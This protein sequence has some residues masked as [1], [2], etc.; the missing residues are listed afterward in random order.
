MENFVQAW[1]WFLVQ[2]LGVQVLFTI[3]VL[4]VAVAGLKQLGFTALADACQRIENALLAMTQA[5][6]TAFVAELK[7]PTPSKV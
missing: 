7:K 4:N 3:G 6:K 5:A 2:N 1:H